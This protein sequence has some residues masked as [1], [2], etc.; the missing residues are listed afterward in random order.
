MIIITKIL[1]SDQGNYT[2]VRDDD[3]GQAEFALDARLCFNL[4]SW[5]PQ[6]GGQ[7]IYIA[8]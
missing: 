8:R 3:L 5:D 6:I 2:L 1:L 7:T 4:A